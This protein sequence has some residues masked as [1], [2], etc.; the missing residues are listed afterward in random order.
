MSRR[1]SFNALAALVLSVAAASATG[2]DSS[3]EG[4]PVG[5]RGGT[6]TSDDG[7][8]TLEVPAGALADEVA[9]RIVEAEDVPADAVGPAYEIQPQGLTFAFPAAVVYDVADGMDVDPDAVRLVVEREDDWSALADRDVDVDNLEVT[10]SML[11]VST[12]AIV[13]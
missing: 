8:V 3:E 12:V 9:I 10:A 1:T 11:F 6:I 4:T 7:R 5:P 2:C 13:E